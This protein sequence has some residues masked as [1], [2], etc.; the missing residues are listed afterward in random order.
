MLVD[1]LIIT[2]KIQ[3]LLSLNL[4]YCIME[5]VFKGLNWKNKGIMIAGKWLNNLRFPDNVIIIEKNTTTEVQEM[6][7]KLIEKEAEAG[8]K[9]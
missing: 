5:G 9:G 6:I 7:V 4:F 2:G 1:K 3:G 8:L